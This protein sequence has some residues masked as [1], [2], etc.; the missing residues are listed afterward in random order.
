ME[1]SRT[2]NSILDWLIAA[3]LAFAAISGLAGIDADFGGVSVRSHSAWRIL[4]LA[5]VLIAARWRMAI[6][7]VPMWLTRMVLRTAICGSAGTW[8]RFLV[9]TIGG[10]DSYGYVSAS[11]VITEGSLR[12]VV[13][14]AEWISAAN[15]MAIASPLGWAPSPDGA[16]IVPAYPL[17]LPVLMA[18]F[19]AVGGNGAVFLVAPFAAAITLW[20]V[21][22][23]TG[24]WYDA[25]TALL[26]TALVAWNPLFITY[27]K[28]PMSDVPATMWVA[29][30]AML[31][32]RATSGT[33]LGA[34]L[35]AG[36]AVITR[37]A[38]LPAAIAIVWVA[39]RGDIAMR[40]AAISGVGLLAG[41]LG[42]MLIQDQLFGSPFSTGYG[43]AAALFSFSHLTANLGIFAVQGWLV[44]GPLWLLGLII[45]LF[46]A[47]PEPRMKPL[48]LFAAV[49]APY[50]FYLPFDHWETLRYLLPGIV[51]LTVTVAHGLMRFSRTPQHAIATAVL[52]CAFIAVAVA[53]SELLMR[54]SE[55]W[56]IAE[57]EARYPLAGRWIDI[58]TAPN[59]VVLANQH[60]GSLR[61]YG[62][63]QTLRWDF[64]AVED[65][66]R[67]VE[68]L[69]TRGATVYVA[70]EGPEVDM[71]NERFAAVIPQLRVDHVGRLRNVLFL[72]LSKK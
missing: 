9:S 18:L 51:V 24:A 27:A 42:Q 23:L 8:L 20:L 57:I 15:R 65:L 7:S 54:R 4:I 6:E 22:R 31:A 62:K 2:R 72:R 70:L 60:S 19:T 16:A 53:Q 59:S 68:E 21:H 55:V 49:A 36:A 1:S 69:E 39:H 11:Q 63:R 34:G 28:Q 40:R 13:P 50:L 52:L 47:R 44:V 5:I 14:V 17:G 48:M 35:A 43:S 64:I 3:T 30:A 38:L 46:A 56:N 61:W 26:A 25:D 67:T 71:F 10:A 29:L 37:P 12:V 32:V 58:N 41:L 33:A 45:G 66:A